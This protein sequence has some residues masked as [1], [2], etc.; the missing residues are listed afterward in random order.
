MIFTNLSV[1]ETTVNSITINWD[2]PENFIPSNLI[3]TVSNDGSHSSIGLNPSAT[4]GTVANL[5]PKT[6]YSVSLKAIADNFWF[7]SEFLHVTT[8]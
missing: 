5:E 6:T 1:S 7:D 2:I 8:A 4:T 3:M